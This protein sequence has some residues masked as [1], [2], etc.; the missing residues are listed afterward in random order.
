MD[1]KKHN[2]NEIADS[3]LHQILLDINA[4]LGHLEDIEADNRE[5]IVKVIKQGNSI[6]QFLKDLELQEV[7]TDDYN[8][9]PTLNSNE[10]P[11]FSK[12]ISTN[13]QELI[14]E[15]MERDKDLKEL[16]KELRKNKD[17]LT[18]GQIGEA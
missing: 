10:S 3:T 8:E 18:P 13:L 1:K 16:E 5:L 9:Y 4:R 15:F 11:K 17:K 14:D 12:N 7:V 2:S 6:V